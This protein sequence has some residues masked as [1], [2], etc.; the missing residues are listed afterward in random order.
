MK[1]ILSFV[2]VIF[3]GFSSIAQANSSAKTDNASVTL[4]S[5]HS[6]VKT[7]DS[8]WLG[9]D[10]TLEPD[11]HIYWKN[12]GD[13]GLEARLEWKLPK[14]V[15]HGPIQWQPPKRIEYS[16]LYNYGYE[17][18]TLLLVPFEIAP[19][20]E[21]G[22][23]TISV[24]ANWL[25][26][27]DICIPE[28]AELSIPV[29]I[30]ENNVASDDAPSIN[31]ALEN[32][33][34]LHIG[35]STYA[36]EGNKIS[37]NI[38]FDQIDNLK[39]VWFYPIDD[40]IIANDSEQ[41]WVATENMIT[42]RANAGASDAKDHMLGVLELTNNDGRVVHYITRATLD[43]DAPTAVTISNKIPSLENTTVST[44]VITPDD[45]IGTSATVESTS[46]FTAI[47][48]ALIGGIILNAMPCVLPILSL[49][50]LS[51]A[52]HS[53]KESH[54]I[55]LHGIAYTLGILASFA[56]IA[57]L[58]IVLQHAGQQIGWGFQLQEPA[59]VAILIYALF[60][61]GLNL[62]GLF[63]LPSSFAGIGSRFT[64]G[65]GLMASFFTG[66]LATLVA[67]PCTA[68]FMAT[69][70]GFALSQPPV[71][72]MAIFLSLGLGLALPYLAICF[73]PPVRHLLP[74]PGAWMERFKQFLAFPMYASA[75]W[76]IWVLAQQSGEMGLAL[77][78]AGLCLIGFT[79]WLVSTMS[80]RWLK[81]IIIII[82][83]AL[84]D[85]TIRSQTTDQQTSAAISEMS[86]PFSQE[87]LDNYRAEGRAVFVNATAAWCITCKV[88]ERIALKD[89]G[90][91][92]VLEENN[93]ISMVADWTNYDENITKYLAS[94]GR[95]GVPIYVYYPPSSGEPKLLPQLLTPSIIIDAINPQ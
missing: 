64:Q 5:D 23:H 6:Q 22:D 68:P 46:I 7:G 24:K 79:A 80:N 69:A 84:L 8:L 25:I 60:L 62:S 58:L 73:I 11:W 57:G 27:K 82:A 1:H 9:L 28:S 70:L 74:K 39:D 71:I 33:P 43:A 94:F 63:E 92:H 34:L 52:S 61:I 48:F 26:C 17:D 21:S 42:I 10:F 16:G 65:S 37:L 18:K 89:S 86:E 88:N 67:T 4:I 35:T 66:L 50:A 19:D 45:T 55:K 36:K 75:A 56:A 40:G 41:Y 91:I 53:D 59:F 30:G 3:I 38:G 20:A 44:D 15:S 12:P 81:V 83:I 13:S 47:L 54:H 32:L 77:V 72:S 2:F 85:T 51:I 49:K 78:L 14:G 93:V 29:T 76:L 87:A 95:N 90:V 31:A